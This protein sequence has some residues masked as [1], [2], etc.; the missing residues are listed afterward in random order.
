MS[1]CQFR[2]RECGQRI[3]VNEQMRDAI[4]ANGCPV[5]KAATEPSDFEP[6]LEEGR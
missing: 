5:C 6:E 4:L 1:E 2:C 3:A